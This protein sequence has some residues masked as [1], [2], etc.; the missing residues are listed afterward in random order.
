VEGRGGG[1]EGEKWVRRLKG[2]EKI[3]RLVGRVGGKEK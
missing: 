2:G 3:E 1:R